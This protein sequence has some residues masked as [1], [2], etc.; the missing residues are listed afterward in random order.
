MDALEGLFV[1]IAMVFHWRI[2]VCIS[3]FGAVG[4]LLATLVPWVN[5]FQGCAL[6]AVGFIVG[7]IWDTMASSNQP[8]RYGMTPTV[9]TLTGAFACLVWGGASSLSMASSISGFV[10][11]CVAICVGTWIASRQVPKASVR[12]IVQCAVVAVIIYI[13]TVIAGTTAL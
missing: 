5:G 12:T 9:A 1:L 7:A 4:F 11:L 3:T 13:V 2:F 10:M 6:A 8:Y